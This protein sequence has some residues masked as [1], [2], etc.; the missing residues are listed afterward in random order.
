MSTYFNDKESSFYRFG[1]DIRKVITT[2]SNRYIGENPPAP[3]VWR[4]FSNDSFLNDQKGRY[5]IDF[6]NRFPKSKYGEVAYAAGKFWSEYPMT[7]GF[8]VCCFS[9]VD[10]FVNGEKVFH[11]RISD[12]RGNKTSTVLADVKKGWN[13]VLLKCTHSASGFGCL[14][15]S[16]NPQWSPINF[17][18]VFEEREGWSGWIYTSPATA[19]PRIE[20]PDFDWQQNEEASGLTW[21]PKIKWDLKKEP[22]NSFERLFGKYTF[23]SVLGWT[24]YIFNEKGKFAFRGKSSNAF[25]IWIDGKQD[26][27][28]DEKGEFSFEIETD[29]YQCDLIVQLELSDE[30]PCFEIY[31]NTAN[32]VCPVSVKG[33][34]GE[35][36]Y[37]GPLRSV[38][39]EDIKNLTTMNFLGEGCTK[40]EYWMPDAPNSV[41]RPFCE[42]ISFGRWTYPLGVTLYG[43]LQAGRFLNNNEYIS[44]VNE[45]VL[46]VAD[47]NDYAQWE[48]ETYGYPGVNHQICWLDALDDCGSF[49]SVMLE[50]CKDMQ[51]ASVKK[52]ADHI[53][54]FMKNKQERQPD[55]A[56]YR[57]LPGN[58]AENTLWADDLYMSVPFL[59]RY[60]RLTGD[61]TYLEDA[62]KQFIL[63]KK[64]LYIEEYSIMS[65]VYDFS[66][67][68]A[69]NVP[70]GRGNGW[71]LFSLTELL[72]NMPSNFYLREQVMDIYL[73][74]CNGYLKLQGENGLWHQVLNHPDSYEETSCTAM[75]VY[76]LARGIRFGWLKE[77][78]D[79]YIDSVRRAVEGMLKNCID[80]FG[81]IYGVCRGSLYSFMPEYYKNELSTRLNDTHGIGIVL[82]A[83]VEYCK[84]TEC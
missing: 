39:Q 66:Y 73:D 48:K 81:N 9:S 19:E 40:K 2:I 46:S 67:N 33:Y 83:L 55:G 77:N 84:V 21:L 64:Y 72:E 80:V 36:L 28:F 1:V 61:E 82:L 37:M 13:T 41:I 63:F 16:L 25:K 53:A 52:L 49:G 24:R 26:Y 27:C 54:D 38:S 30:A 35:W 69:T 15:A 12:E 76:S 20:Q 11:S 51:R 29:K 75:F 57:N 14:F 60:Y 5:I 4:N 6:K 62:A 47:I 43:L 32:N 10:I 34:N 56:F 8:Q 68:T 65:H 22:R 42:N 71:V 74:L 17:S 7:E 58:P 70:W 45:H 3:F 59:V 50:T 31:R 23:G 79:L 78:S 18:S 44:Y